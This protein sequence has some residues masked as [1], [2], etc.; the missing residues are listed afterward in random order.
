MKFGDINKP[1]VD[2]GDKSLL[3]M[4][5]EYREATRYAMRYCF[6]H[7]KLRRDKIR[8]T[9]DARLQAIEEAAKCTNRKLRLKKINRLLKGKKGRV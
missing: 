8:A 7:T 9:I 5:D 4:L 6:D 1:T 2:H 3:Q